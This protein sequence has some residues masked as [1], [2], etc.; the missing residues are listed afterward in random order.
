MVHATKH[1]RYSAPSTTLLSSSITMGVATIL[2]AK[3]IYLL[4]W[5]EEKAHMVKECVEGNV[6]DTHSGIL[7]TD[8]QQCTCS[9]RPVNSFQ[10]DTHSTSMAGLVTSCEWNDKLI[11]SAIMWLCHWP[12]NQS[13]NWLIKITTKMAWASCLPSSDLNTNVN[14]KIFQRP[15]AHHYRMA[16]W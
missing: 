14:I 9:Y 16:G 13:W 11:R 8:P 3:K 6:T 15:A 12:A 7:L 4:A 5:G 2:A 10:P 1:P